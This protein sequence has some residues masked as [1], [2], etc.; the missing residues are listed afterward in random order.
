MIRKEILFML[1]IISVFTLKVLAGDDEEA[2]KQAVK[3]YY[4]LYFVKMDK[5][6]YRSI[7][8]RDYLLLE[9]GEILDTGGDIAAMPAP[10]SGYKRT[11]SF[12]F[13]LVRVE[14][15]IAYV[16]YFLKSEINDKVNGIRNKEWLESVILRRSGEDWK[17]ALLHSTR[18][19]NPAK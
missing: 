11:D 18:I 10:D 7:L 4:D 17:I 15:D 5:G 13:R 12:D 3:N 1:L 16:V 9:N 19:A 6:E 8:T 14:G 2:V